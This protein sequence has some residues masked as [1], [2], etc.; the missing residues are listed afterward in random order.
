[1]VLTFDCGRIIDTKVEFTNKRAM[2]TLENIKVEYSKQDTT[3]EENIQESKQ[4]QSVHSQ[5]SK[6]RSTEENPVYA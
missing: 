5:D 2:K 1:M 6:A 3:Q 4:S